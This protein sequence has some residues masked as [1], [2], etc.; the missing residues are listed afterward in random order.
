MD[1]ITHIHAPLLMLHGSQD[2]TVPVRLGERLFAAANAPKRWL[3]I[4]NAA[5][6]DLDLA[7]PVRYQASSSISCFCSC[8]G[9]SKWIPCQPRDR[10]AATLPATSSMKMVRP[11][12]SA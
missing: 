8:T 2:D 5:R 7:D 9:D 12:S 4:E 11:G 3:V 6:S 10:A 1:K